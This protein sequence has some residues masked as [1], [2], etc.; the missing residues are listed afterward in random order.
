MVEDEID[1][2]TRRTGPAAQIS[3]HVPS[4]SILNSQARIWLISEKKS[5][6]NA[7]KAVKTRITLIGIVE[8]EKIEVSAGGNGRRT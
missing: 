5:D 8:A 4:I 7:E 3:G 2:M 6:R 1:R